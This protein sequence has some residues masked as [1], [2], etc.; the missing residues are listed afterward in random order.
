MVLA[1]RLRV[2][3]VLAA[4]DPS[5]AAVPGAPVPWVTPTEAHVDGPR[6]LT[7]PPVRGRGHTLPQ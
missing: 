6:C 3:E 2:L 1:A 7:H 5:W 4:G